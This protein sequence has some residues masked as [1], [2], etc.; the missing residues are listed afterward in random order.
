MAKSKLRGFYATRK[1]LTVLVDKK[2]INLVQKLDKRG[3]PVIENGK[4][5]YTKEIVITKE[6]PV[7]DFIVRVNNAVPPTHRMLR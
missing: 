5:V 6:H 7:R 3:Y 1:D 4:P 2:T